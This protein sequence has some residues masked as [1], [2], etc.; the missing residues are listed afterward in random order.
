MKDTRRLT[1]LCSG[2]L[3]YGVCWALAWLLADIHLPGD[4]FPHAILSRGSLLSVLS[5]AGGIAL[6]LFAIALV[7]SYFTVRSIKRGKRPTTG[8]C[9][10]G[11]GLAWFAGLLIGVFSLSGAEHI[12][13]QSIGIL[14][15]S[16]TQPPLWGLLNTLALLMGATVAGILAGKHYRNLGGGQGRTMA[17][18]Y[19]PRRET[20][21]KK[22]SVDTAWLATR[23]MS[24]LP[25]AAHGLHL[26]LGQTGR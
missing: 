1:A 10:A 4:V 12:G 15:L 17:A 6:L 2:L 8:W 16:A 11:L 7:W 26:P 21:R 18:T 20:T 22:S 5:E 3:M 19:L 9:I 23:P 24:D 13:E 25:E 14:L